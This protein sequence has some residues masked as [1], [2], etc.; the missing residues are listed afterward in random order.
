MNQWN[1]SMER[2]SGPMGSL[3]D[4]QDGWGE[5]IITRSLQSSLQVAADQ[6]YWAQPSALNIYV[7][8]FLWPLLRYEIFT[9]YENFSITSYVGVSC[10]HDM[11][12]AVWGLESAVPPLPLL[13]PAQL[14]PSLLVLWQSVL[15]QWAGAGRPVVTACSAVRQRLE[16]SHSPLF[17]HH[18]CWPAWTNEVGLLF[19]HQLMW[20]SNV[21]PRD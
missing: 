5:T 15:P 4:R 9:D 2:V 10:L 6:L 14:L 1:V 3:H 20:G 17:S 11:V 19:S 12:D 8:C 13:T 7:F 21:S 18:C 16:D